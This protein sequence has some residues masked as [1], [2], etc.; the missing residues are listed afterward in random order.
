[1]LLHASRRA[2]ISRKKRSGNSPL[3]QWLVCAAAFLALAACA[4]VELRPKGEV[5][6]GGGVETRR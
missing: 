5:V 3:R 1:M 2:R 4:S 6:I